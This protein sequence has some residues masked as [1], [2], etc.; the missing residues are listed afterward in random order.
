MASVWQTE[1]V[2]QSDVFHCTRFANADG[3]AGI[4]SL[5][6][7]CPSNSVSPQCF[8]GNMIGGACFVCVCVFH[9]STYCILLP[10]PPTKVLLIPVCVGAL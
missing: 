7:Q 9:S 3:S 1:E 8:K 10:Y 4:L 2:V 5:S 6:I